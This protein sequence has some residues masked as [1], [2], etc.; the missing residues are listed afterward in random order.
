MVDNRADGAETNA[1]GKT[2]RFGMLLFASSI[3]LGAMLACG[4]T[5]EATVKV[6][7]RPTLTPV[8]TDTNMLIDI[9]QLKSTAN[10]Y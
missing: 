1:I 4:S 7:L 9:P 8:P 3:W 6:T 5:P 2:E 10:A